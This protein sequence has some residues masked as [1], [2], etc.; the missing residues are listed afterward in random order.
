MFKSLWTVLKN[1]SVCHP[2]NKLHR[3]MADK[4]R[5]KCDKEAHGHSALIDQSNC[6]PYV[7]LFIKLVGIYA[8]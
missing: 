4:W 7:S 2:L 5:E 3:D 8:M 6:P 1:I